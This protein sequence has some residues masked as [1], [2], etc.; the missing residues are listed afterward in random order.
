MQ[1]DLAVGR[2]SGFVGKTLEQLISGSYT[3][4]DETMYTLLALLHDTEK[5]QLEP[6]ALAGMT[7]PIHL[8]ENGVNLKNA[9]HIVWA[10]GGGMVPEVK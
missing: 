3:I 5:I 2:P 10:T 1:M 9:T 8:A 4:S 6:S 7:G